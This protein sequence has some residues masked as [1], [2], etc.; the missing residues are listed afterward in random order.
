MILLNKGSAV[1]NVP[2]RTWFL[3]CNDDML[4]F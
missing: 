2:E 3:V 1:R 4:Q